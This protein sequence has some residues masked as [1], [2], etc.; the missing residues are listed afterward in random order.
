MSRSIDELTKAEHE[1]IGRLESVVGTIEEKNELLETSGIFAAFDDLYRQYTDNEDLE[2]LKRAIFYFWF[3]QAEPSFLSGLGELKE[4]TNDKVFAKLDAIAKKGEIDG[5]LAWMLPYYYTITDWLFDDIYKSTGPLKQVLTHN[6]DRW[7][8]DCDP[9][10]F[11]N[12]G[13]MGR[14]WSSRNLK[15]S[16]GI[17]AASRE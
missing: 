7:Q 2:A 13:L 8:F 5:E 11:R 16:R 4:E 3:Q 9:K 12:R 6:G 10:A 1:L 15:A 17:K 14:Y